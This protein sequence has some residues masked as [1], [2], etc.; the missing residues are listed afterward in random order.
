MVM[1]VTVQYEVMVKML[2]D[3]GITTVQTYIPIIS[4]KVLMGCKLVVVGILFNS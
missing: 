2:E 3:G 1:A 4:T